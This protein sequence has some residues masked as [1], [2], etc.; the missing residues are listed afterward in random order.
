MPVFFEVNR[1]ISSL[2]GIKNKIKSMGF[3]GFYF[4]AALCN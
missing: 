1:L 4:Y 3:V 2:S